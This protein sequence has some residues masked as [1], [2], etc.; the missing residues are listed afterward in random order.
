VAIELFLSFSI[1]P[2]RDSASHIRL[3]LLEAEPDSSRQPFYSFRTS[4]RGLRHFNRDDS[5]FLD[6]GLQHIAVIDDYAKHNIHTA[7]FSPK[8]R[9]YH[10]AF[11]SEFELV[12]A[13]R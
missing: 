6:G 8:T 4:R 5:A 7:G 3:T 9:R 2:C 13:A 12:Q 1:F 11:L 10:F